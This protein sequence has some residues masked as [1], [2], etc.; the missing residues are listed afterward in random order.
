MRPTKV[1][2]CTFGFSKSLEEQLNFVTV[3]KKATNFWHWFSDN[4]NKFSFINEVQEAERDNL[5]DEF[6]A[7]LH[8]FND[9]I[10]FEI[11][12]DLDDDKKEL[13][14]T[15]EGVMD[16]F[17]EVETLVSAAPKFEK[18]DVIAF[19]PPMGKGFKTNYAGIEFDP[20]KVIFIPLE[21]EEQPDAIGINVCYPDFDE[22]DREVL[23]E[24]TY[25]MLDTIIG[26]K[27]TTLD[28]NYL[29][30]TQTPE[31]VADLN[32][33]CCSEIGEYIEDKKGRF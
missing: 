26:E 28:I 33:M 19:K 23:M 7:E 25:L 15:A 20:E 32:F 8:Q 9:N 10:Y 30:I 17:P 16:Y 22:S 13:I 6:I 12:G 2:F 4:Q 11:G 24:G 1:F 21:N 14:I 5:L 31:N 27:S 18:W 3:S 29:E